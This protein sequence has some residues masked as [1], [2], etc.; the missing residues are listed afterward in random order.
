MKNQVGTLLISVT[1]AAFVYTSC[2]DNRGDGA[3]DESSSQNKI[4]NVN[5]KGRWLL[6]NIVSGD[7]VNIRLSY[8]HGDSRQYVV[9]E[10]SE[11]F[12][13]T[14]CNSFSGSYTI[15]GDSILLG[16][17]IMTEKAC[18]DMITEDALRKILPDIVA[19]HIE[20][21]S[22]VRLDSRNPS[23]Y[24]VLRKDINENEKE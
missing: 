13:Q 8:D 16:D 1:A 3:S 12:I 7:T 4:A 5:I 6:D 18:D 10:D 23:E 9:F 2:G 14:N 19:V 11:Y 15:C 24:I 21:D 17:G 20:N 22:I